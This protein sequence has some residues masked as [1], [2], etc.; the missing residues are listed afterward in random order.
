MGNETLPPT[1]ARDG[2]LL[3]ARPKTFKIQGEAWTTFGGAV[4]EPDFPLPIPLGPWCPGAGLGLR[5]ER[6]R[7]SADAV[8]LDSGPGP[9]PFLSNVPTL[10]CIWIFGYHSFPAIVACDVDRSGRNSS[11]AVVCAALVFGELHPWQTTYNINEKPLT[12]FS[13]ST[14]AVPYLTQYLALQSRSGTSQQVNF[15]QQLLQQLTNIENR[16]ALFDIR[17]ASI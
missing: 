10:R 6:W 8:H 1:R 7:S 2:Q 13:S 4:G 11:T 9:P 17:T 3:A 12:E 16:L 5:N 14:T 15:G